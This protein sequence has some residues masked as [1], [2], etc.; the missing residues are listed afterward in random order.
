MIKNLE[1][2]V[3]VA[4]LLNFGEAARELNYSQST[5]SE[6]I[7]SLEAELGVRLFERMG[8]KVFL[9]NE[10]TR[11]LPYA[12]RLTREI[13]NLKSLF[14]S[15]EGLSG[16]IVIGA[17]ETL[18]TYWL[19]PLLKEYRALYPNVQINIKVGNCVDFPQWLQQDFVDVAF[20]LREE[21]K[22]PQ[23][24]EYTLF[25]GNTVFFAAPDYELAAREIIELSDLAGHTLLMPEGDSGYPMELKLLL[26]KTQ[27][28]A[29]TILE[30]G[31]LELIKQC[32]KNGLG[33]SLLPEIA[34]EQEIRRGELVK[35]NWLSGAISAKAL[36]VFHRD[37]WLSPPL[38]A[39]KNLI[40]AKL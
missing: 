31:S 6:Q 26:K 22:E 12:K 4:R 38:A 13:E 1:S 33:V 25:S 7:R 19:P 30:F 24:I 21:S 9:T 40:L 11:L 14:Q 8:R 28:A 18:C 29:N 20:S 32:V 2:F 37:K 17:A 39:L 16:T 10:G 15:E 36:M 5:V 35:L 3:T 23:L 34:V 27:V